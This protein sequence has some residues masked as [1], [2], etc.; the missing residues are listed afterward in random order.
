MY[1]RRHRP[2]DVRVYNN[3]DTTYVE[4]QMEE[5]KEGE[6]EMLCEKARQTSAL[7]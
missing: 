6:G 2:K 4:L 7:V 5:W 3:I 1:M